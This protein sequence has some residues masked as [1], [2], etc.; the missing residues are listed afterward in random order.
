MYRIHWL[1]RPWDQIVNAS[2]PDRLHVKDTEEHRRM[3]QV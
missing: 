3:V 2:S 1:Q